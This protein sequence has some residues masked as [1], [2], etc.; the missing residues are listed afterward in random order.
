[1]YEYNNHSEIN[2]YNSTVKEAWIYE[3]KYQCPELISVINHS[4]TSALMFFGNYLMNK[5]NTQVNNCRLAG[6]G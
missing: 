5:M 1:M 4:H 3:L 2:V 6:S